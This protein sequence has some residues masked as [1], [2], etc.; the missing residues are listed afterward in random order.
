M[1]MRPI[2]SNMERVKFW[3]NKQIDQ[4]VLWMNEDSIGSSYCTYEDYTD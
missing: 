2:N 1:E 4:K 3:K